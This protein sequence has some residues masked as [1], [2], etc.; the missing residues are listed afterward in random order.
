[1]KL[2]IT[3]LSENSAGQIH[4]LGE[5][6]FSLLLESDEGTILFD[7]GLGDAILHNADVLGIDLKRVDKIVISHAHIDH[8]GGLPQVL[9][10]IGRAVE[11]IA[12][13]EMWQEKFMVRDN[14]PIDYVGAPNVRPMLETLGAR[15]TLTRTAQQLSEHIWVSG[16]IPDVSGFE[17][18]GAPQLMLREKEKLLRDPLIDTRSL[19]IQLD[20]GLVVIT[21]CGHRG[22]VNELLQAKKITGCERIHAFLGGMHLLGA[23][24]EHIQRTLE[25]FQCLDVQYLAPMHCTG[26]RA[27]A[28]MSLVYGK[29]LLLSTA[30]SCISFPVAA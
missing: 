7:T 9:R 15:F 22:P 16:E 25:A 24:D 19:I 28:L 5:W 29:N 20:E 21:G 12:A 1:M 23:A 4:L 10:R 18:I 3:V 26:A 14:V 11:V 17:M 6:G 30:G 2:K 27:V 13:P 8:V